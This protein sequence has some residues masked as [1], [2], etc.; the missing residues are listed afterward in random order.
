MKKNSLV[1]SLL[2]WKSV[3]LTE[4]KKIPVQK[5]VKWVGE[6]NT[7]KMTSAKNNRLFGATDES[8]THIS[9]ATD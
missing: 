4:K 2:T 1:F 8:H 5:T 6:R 3:S 7:E 9:Q